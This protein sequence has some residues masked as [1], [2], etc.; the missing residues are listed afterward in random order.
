MQ[1]ESAAMKLGS[2]FHSAV[3]EPMKFKEDYL[4][5]PSTMPDGEP[6]NRR[7]KAHKEYL[8]Q[9]ALENPNKVALSEDE[10]DT[11]T[12]MLNSLVANPIAN[13][14]FKGGLAEQI[15]FDTWDAVNV[16]GKCDYFQEK[17][18]LLGDRILVELKSSTDA[19]PEGFARDVLKMHYDFQLY[20]YEQ[21]FKADRCFIVA[22]ENKFPYATGVYDMSEFLPNGK[23]KVELAF[24]KLKELEDHNGVS[25]GYTKSLEVLKVPSWIAAQGD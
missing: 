8:E 4:Q 2:A 18:P 6:I 20:F 7:K 13:S 5:L 22:V 19:S 17:H 16:K 12:G 14:L 3:L 21:L 1:R 10:M 9:I 15:K 24:S 11:L 23:R 25:Y